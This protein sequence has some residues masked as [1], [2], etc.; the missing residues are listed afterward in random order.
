MIAIQ[1]IF[2]SMSWKIRSKM[3]SAETELTLGTINTQLSTKWQN[4]LL[5]II[6]RHFDRNGQKNIQCKFDSKKYATA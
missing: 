1:Q 2:F 4:Y 3:Q 6:I 5:L